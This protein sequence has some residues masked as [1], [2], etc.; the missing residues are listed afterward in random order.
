VFGKREDMMY[1]AKLFI[2][3]FK[4]L[5]FPTTAWIRGLVCGRC[6]FLGFVQLLNTATFPHRDPVLHKVVI[7]V[8]PSPRRR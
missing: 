8:C 4:S 2:Y 1:K 3:L 5:V 6:S 7:H